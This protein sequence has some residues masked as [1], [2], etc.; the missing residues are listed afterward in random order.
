MGPV[1]SSV[2]LMSTDVVVWIGDICQDW[3]DKMKEDKDGYMSRFKRHSAFGFELCRAAEAANKNLG[4]FLVAS[5][6]YFFGGGV[7]VSFVN[8]FG[9]FFQKFQNL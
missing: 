6:L 4:P 9:N 8:I 7:L 1:S 3:A 5:Y 2:I